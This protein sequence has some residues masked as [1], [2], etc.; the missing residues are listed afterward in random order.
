M[1][2][3]T[4][5]TVVLAM[6]GRPA[7]LS[8]AHFAALSQALQ[9][10]DARP[11]KSEFL[12][13][14]LALFQVVLA[15]NLT[16][17]VLFP[18]LLLAF[19]VSVTWT[20]MIHTLRTEAIEGG[21]LDGARHVVTRGLLR[22]TALATLASLALATCFF[23]VLPRVKSSF[24]RGGLGGPLAMAGF[25]DQV[26]LGTIG[27]I[28]QD[29][30]VVLRVETLRGE[31]AA[32]I[33][34]YWRGLAFDH[35]DGRRWSISSF[36]A[37]YDRELL[38]GHA[39]FGLNVRGRPAEDALVQRIVREPVEAGVVFA[40]GPIMRVEGPLKQLERD[41]NGGVYD[42][43]QTDQRIR[44]T[45]WSHAGHRDL[46]SLRTDDAIPPSET[47]P[48]SVLRQARYLELPDFDPEVLALASRITE[49]AATDADRAEAIERHL[50][51]N[52]HY[53]DSPD[54]MT[55]GGER[56]PIEGFLLGDL[57]GHCE[58]FA[59]GM[60]VLARAEGLPARLVNGFAG[61][62]VNEVGGFTELTASDAHAWVEIHYRDAGWVRY[63]PTPPDLRMRA[64]SDGT[65]AETIAA[66]G[67][68][69][70]LWWFQRVVDFD[71]SDQILALKSAFVFFRDLWE[72][73]PK[74]TKVALP[75]DR[76]REPGTSGAADPGD[77]PPHLIALFAVAA[78][79]ALLGLWLRSRDAMRR[80]G[81]PADYARA[82]RWLARR[83]HPRPRASTARDF[84]ENLAST[85]HPTVAEA[86]SPITERYLRHR[87][88]G[89][90]EAPA[91][92][93]E[94]DLERLRAALRAARPTLL[95]RAVRLVGLGDQPDVAQD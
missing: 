18:P 15:S 54:D 51:A 72:G 93:V 88:G 21:D 13:V 84:V 90:G 39:R 71:S 76:R 83:G 42:P 81:V 12:L 17:S 7:T 78:G 53:T 27:R 80:D 28:R 6:R 66:L 48:R 40:A 65:L 69:L 87:F 52:G 45:V 92:A 19:L 62:R 55:S 50:R 95:E 16:D 58:Y 5:L 10:I 46:A 60:V 29:D 24:V 3:V 9:L 26:E 91:G 67:S 43:S 1:L 36:A 34:A 44:Y 31:P 23:L 22:T 38:N 64:L 30:T 32:P 89:G 8:L 86:F 25:S 68:A 70:E 77:G 37:G 33:D 4:A 79:L 94:A 20:L 41:T 74:S 49:G 14:A 57:A 73:A 75:T 47:G 2:A 82:L 85:L 59:S 11:R 61:G 56:S 63:D 35:F